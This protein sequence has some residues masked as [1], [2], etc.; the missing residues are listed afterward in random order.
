VIELTKTFFI[1][2]IDLE[3]Y[4]S[5]VDFR[6]ARLD[7]YISNNFEAGLC[8]GG[9]WLKVSSNGIGCMINDGDIRSITANRDASSICIDYGSGASCSPA[10][11]TWV[12]GLRD[13]SIDAACTLTPT[14]SRTISSSKSRTS[15][16]SPT[17]SRTSSVTA[18]LSVGALPSVSSSLTPTRT[19]T[20]TPSRT[21]S[22]SISSTPSAST[23]FCDLVPSLIDGTTASVLG[24]IADRAV[25]GSSS[26]FYR[27]TGVSA[28]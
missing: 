10:T 3:L 24:A 5:E 8:P 15:S 22:P 9:T 28:Q 25:D 7:V 27:A 19:P 21:L 4:S 18:S 14:P 17:P 13:V 2:T 16:P 20:G 23:A 1:N 26:T 6:N 12:F 11:A